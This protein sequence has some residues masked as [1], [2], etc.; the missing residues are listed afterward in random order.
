MK[1]CVVYGDA[2][3]GPNGVGSRDP[4]VTTVSLSSLRGREFQVL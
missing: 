2:L 3:M 4:P 1:G